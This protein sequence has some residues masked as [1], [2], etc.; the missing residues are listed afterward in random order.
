MTPL[1]TAVAVAVAA[2]VAAAAAAA[3]YL[4]FHNP[5]KPSLCI[6]PHIGTIV[7]HVSS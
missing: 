2:A 3:I 7:D 4:L 5:I 1:C 6:L